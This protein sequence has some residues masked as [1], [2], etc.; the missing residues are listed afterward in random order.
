MWATNFMATYPT[1]VLIIDSGSSADW[2]TNHNVMQLHQGSDADTSEDFAVRNMGTCLD[3]RWNTNLTSNVFVSSHIF[4]VISITHSIMD[5]FR[6]L[7]LFAHFCA[8]I[9][10]RYTSC[11]DYPS[12]KKSVQM[13]I[14]W[15]FYNH[16]QWATQHCHMCFDSR[17]GSGAC[18]VILQIQ[19]E[20]LYNN[21]G[22]VF[23]VLENSN[24]MGRRS[25]K[26]KKYVQN[27]QNT[28]WKVVMSFHLAVRRG[29]KG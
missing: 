12:K 22:H 8:I 24:R 7:F 5:A 21:R 27:W 4:R 25:P 23:F 17:Q 15:N 26:V 20:A 14:F 28:Q 10:D 19:M 2:W 16:W 9:V 18:E 3:W 29:W 6:T 11:M 1:A 13:F